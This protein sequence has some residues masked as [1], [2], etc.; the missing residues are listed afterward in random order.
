M[1]NLYNKLTLET[2][3][4]ALAFSGPLVWL[5]NGLF[6]I[7]L[8]TYALGSINVI[9][10][11]ITA[12]AVL[13]MFITSYVKLNDRLATYLMYIGVSFP[14]LLDLVITKVGIFIDINIWYTILYTIGAYLILAATLALVENVARL[15]PCEDRG[16]LSG[17]FI[18]IT[19]IGVTI[20]SALKVNGVPFV[21]DGISILDITIL[22]VLGFSILIKPWNFERHNYTVHGTPRRYAISWFFIGL[23]L[24]TWYIHAHNLKIMVALSN[25]GFVPLGDMPH[26]G[27]VVIAISALIS[28]MLSDRLGRRQ[29]ATIGVLLLAGLSIY[30]PSFSGQPELVS[31]LSIIQDFV[32]GYIVGIG[33][34]LIW[35]EIGSYQN[36]ARRIF[37]AWT[38]MILLIGGAMFVH[39]NEFVFPLTLGNFSLSLAITFALIAFYPLAQAPEVLENEVE[40]EKLE[41]SIDQGAVQAA[42]DDIIQNKSLDEIVIGSSEELDRELDVYLSEE[43]SKP[44]KRQ[45][46]KTGP[47]KTK[48]TT[49]KKDIPIGEQSVTKIK[50]VGKVT[51]ERMKRL[52]YS[53]IRSVSLADPEELAFHLKIS[54]QR[55]RK[56]VEEAEKMMESEE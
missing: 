32:F 45:A 36:K 39:V 53:T 37:Y 5:I 28:G 24:I 50:G 30:T 49:K 17:L 31:A 44:V 29:T 13:G 11:I 21:V 27:S 3:I 7:Y 26:I 33:M 47:V 52:G 14:I 51:A 55:A 46:A 25:H 1:R 56:I 43:S 6:D 48:S 22:G 4:F 10:L 40:I 34:F 19:M 42:V 2:T 23:S 20:L 15:V 16:K 35:G 9:P 54:L 18:F 38:Y 41:I 12:A 8:G